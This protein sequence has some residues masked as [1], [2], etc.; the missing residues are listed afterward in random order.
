MTSPGRNS[1]EYLEHV[2]PR[3][4]R[5]SE[6]RGAAAAAQVFWER[7]IKKVGEPEAKKIM[8]HE[9]GD[10]KPGPPLTDEGVAL[11]ML[12]YTYLLHWGSGQTDAKIAKRIFE[13][14]PRYL[15]YEFR[16]NSLCEQRV[17]RGVHEF[18]G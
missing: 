3:P 12:I 18:A 13:S 1:E 7:L 14:E 16:R 9:M 4:Q 6:R 10:K 11:R 8:R 17:Y 2:K 5:D 15:H